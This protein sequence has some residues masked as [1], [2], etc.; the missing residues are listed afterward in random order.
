MRS[1]GFV[2]GRATMA[3]RPP[4][5]CRNPTERVAFIT[6][7]VPY[8]GV[9]RIDPI[10]PARQIGSLQVRHGVDGVAAVGRVSGVGSAKGA[11]SALPLVRFP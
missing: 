9:N 8:S 4:G 3:D 5:H 11:V 10:H 2:M 7:P 6:S 1:V